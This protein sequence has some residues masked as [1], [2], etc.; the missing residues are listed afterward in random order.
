MRWG[1][2]VPPLEA[3]SPPGAAPFLDAGAAAGDPHLS[4]LLSAH[5]TCEH[6]SG[7][8][9]YRCE[10]CQTAVDATKTTTINRVPNILVS[11]ARAQ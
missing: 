7:D 1:A 10:G 8:N 3:L 6:L 5:L 11:G 2:Q 4:Q 9:A